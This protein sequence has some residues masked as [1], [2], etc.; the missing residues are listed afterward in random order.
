MV[1]HVVKIETYIKRRRGTLRNYLENKK[2]D[3]LREAEVM[4]MHCG[5]INKTLWWDKKWI[6]KDQLKELKYFLFKY[7][8]LFL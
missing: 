8:F 1:Y 5:D 6:D 3:L 4:D 2:G 7:C